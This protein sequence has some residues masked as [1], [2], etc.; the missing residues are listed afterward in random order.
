MPGQ[1]QGAKRWRVPQRAW[2][3]AG[4]LLLVWLGLASPALA[5]VDPYVS[6][7]LRATGPVELP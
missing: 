3:W 1:T 4:I 5:R 6:Q 7:Y 2:R